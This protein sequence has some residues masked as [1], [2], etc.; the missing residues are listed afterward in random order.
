MFSQLEFHAIRDVVVTQWQRK[1][2]PMQLAIVT[3]VS[4]WLTG[5]LGFVIVLFAGDSPPT[6]DDRHGTHHRGPGD[7]GGAHQARYS[8]F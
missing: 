1:F 6:R 4:L 8:Y 3:V 2:W 7:C 5:M